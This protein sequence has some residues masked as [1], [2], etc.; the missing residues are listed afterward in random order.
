MVLE[1]C[2]ASASYNTSTTLG[3]PSAGKTH[4]IGFKA[5]SCT[6]DFGQSELASKSSSGQEEILS[7]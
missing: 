3:P 7:L 1:R 5:V 6:V 2:L 4:N